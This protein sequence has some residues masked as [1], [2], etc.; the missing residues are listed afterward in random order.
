MK[1]AVIIYNNGKGDICFANIPA[2]KLEFSDTHI[3]V[4]NEGDLVGCFK[5][6]AVIDVHLSSKEVKQ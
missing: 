6:E 3:F 5:T 1:K 2:D 4:F